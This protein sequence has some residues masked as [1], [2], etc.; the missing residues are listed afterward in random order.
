MTAAP[1]A[2]TP[3]DAA[4]PPTPAPSGGPRPKLPAFHRDPP[5]QLSIRLEADDHE[6]LEH[7]TRFYNQ[8]LGA[9]VAAADVAAHI[10]AEWIGRDRAF[11]RW[12]GSRPAAE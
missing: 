11:R 2:P 9:D 6:R 5:R 7:Y 1:T 10:V 4:A 3:T 8:A 12:R